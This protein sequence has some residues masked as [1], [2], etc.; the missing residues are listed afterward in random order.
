MYSLCVMKNISTIIVSFLVLTYVQFAWGQTPMK[1]DKTY[2]IP[3]ALEQVYAA[4]VSSDT[5]IP[6]ATRMDIKPVVGGHYRLFM[7]TPEFQGT[8]EGEFLSVEPNSHVVYTWEWNGDG[9]VSTISVLFEAAD[10][11]TLVTIAHDGFDKAESVS[12]HDS[13]WDSYVE[14]F[15]KHLRS[16]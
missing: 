3:F 7:D 5:V 6:P 4:W 1:I 13:G 9:E 14:G 11:G 16:Q 15:V 2:T 10:E 8:N 12:N